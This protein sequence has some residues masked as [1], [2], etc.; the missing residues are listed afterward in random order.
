VRSRQ[1]S[2]LLTLVG[3]AAVSTGIYAQSLEAQ[4]K[5]TLPPIFIQQ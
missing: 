2:V 1:V 4:A 5:V 3:T